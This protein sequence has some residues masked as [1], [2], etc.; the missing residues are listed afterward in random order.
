MLSS[1]F[2]ITID[3]VVPPVVHSPCSVPEALREPLRKE[4]DSLVTQGILA[5]VSKPTDWVN[6]L[7]CV[8]KSNGALRLCLDPKD[9]SRGIKRP[10]Y[11][12]PTLEDILP[13]LSSTRY[14]STLDARSSY[15][16]IELDQESSLCNSLFGRYR[17]LCLPFGLIC[18]Q[19]IFQRK[20]NETFGDLSRVTGIA[21]DIV[22][23][24]YDDRNHDKN[25]SAVLQHAFETGLRSASSSVLVFHSSV[26]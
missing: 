11:L 7:V 26:T 21:D 23:Y 19:D 9:L 24:G 22:V 5:K 25:L 2:H 14:F 6:S 3:A 1:E 8:T 12:T 15:W 17:F 13:K 20:V 18:S 4:L 10:H 16:N